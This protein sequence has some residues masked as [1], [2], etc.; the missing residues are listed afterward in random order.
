MARLAAPSP[1][2][3]SRHAQAVGLRYVHD[4]MPGIRRRRAGRGFRYLAP[5][6]RPLRA[7]PERAR[8]EALAIPPAW[9]DVWICPLANGH[10]Q[11]TGRDARGRKQYRYHP[12]WR[13]V[14]DQTKYER[15]LAFLGALPALR[16]RVGA[17]L[18]RPG[19]PRAK[20]LAALVRL[21]ER[22][23]VRVGN[24]DYARANGSF[25]LTTLRSRH[26]RVRGSRILLA[27]RGK[28][29]KRHAV[30]LDDPRLARIVRRC[31][32]VPGYELF[33]YLDED[34]ES[35][36]V[37]S[38]DVNAYLREAT[39][40]EYSAKDFRTWAGTMLAALAL[41]DAPAPGSQRRS[42][43]A[44][45][46]AIAHVAEHLGNTPAV[47][48]SCYV[49]PA[50]VESYLDGTLA[51]ALRDTTRAESG[52]WTRRDERAVMRLLARRPARLAA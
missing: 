26:A 6:G 14:R 34:G 27:F 48:R 4:R 2:D 21:L 31:R 35:R 17:D 37:D 36:A 3:P 12:R 10:I 24:A 18:A 45:A 50:V 23:F 7:A 51:P 38:A 49:H 9:R 43:R 5:D 44:V 11:A 8:I 52:R 39:G 13:A 22:T 32:D 16:R 42:R 29:G 41:R 33:R 25:G 46:A 19:L 28:G 20:V 40:A 30:A 15:T 1:D 47:C